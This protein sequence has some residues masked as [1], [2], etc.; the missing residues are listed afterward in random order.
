MSKKKKGI[1]KVLRYR[2]PLHLNVGM[3]VFALIFVYMVFSVSAYVRR[4]KVQFYEVTEGSIVS[5]KSYTGIILRQEEVKYAENTGYVNYYVREGKRASL[6]T[7][8]YSVDETGK[9]ASFLADNSDDTAVLTAQN[10]TE[11]KSRLSAFSLA[12]DSTKFRSVY[13]AKYTLEAQVMEYMNFNTL[14]T[15]GK[16]TEEAG[17]MLEQVAADRAGVVSY[18]IDS[19]EGFSQEE[20]SEA[21]FDRSTYEK[22]ITKSGKLMEQGAPV[23][24]MIT[25]D[26]WSL[27]FPLSEEDQ[28]SYQEKS[29]LWVEFTGRDLKASGSFSVVTGSDGKPYGKL[30]FDR[31]MVQFASQRYLDFEV[32]AASAG[33][34]KIPVTSVIEKDFYLIPKEYLAQGGGSSDSGFYKETYSDSGTSVVFTPAELYYGDGENYYIEKGRENGICEGDYLVK[35]DSPDRFLV[36]PSGSLKGVYCINKGYAVFKQIDVLASND[37]YYSVRKNV[38]YGLSVYDHIVLDGTSVQEGELVYQ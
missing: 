10:L 3:I 11:L 35:P 38:T 26:L 14:D 27:M 5:N 18:G 31:Y 33:G 23:Y 25:S 21:V 37:E 12:Y 28:E 8:I 7:R 24:K 1:K 13:D 32:A 20:I 4:N 19:F 29:N 15:L 6:G 22:A 17:I 9:L 2:R 16:L 30:D 36:G 34:L